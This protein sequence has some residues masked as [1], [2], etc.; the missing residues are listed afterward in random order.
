MP[1]AIKEC[2]LACKPEVYIMPLIQLRKLQA[3]SV[4]IAIIHWSTW[5]QMWESESFLYM[6]HRVYITAVYV[7]VCIM[8]CAHGW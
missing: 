8:V 3:I 5:K 2:V 4:I 7:H 6:F 1:G